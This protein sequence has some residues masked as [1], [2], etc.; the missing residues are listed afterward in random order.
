[1]AADDRARAALAELR[2]LAG[3]PDAQARSALGLLGGRPDR[4]VLDAALACLGRHPLPEARPALLD[5][6]AAYD[7]PLAKRDLGCHVRAAIMA[8][9][10]HVARGADL[11]VVER[12]LATYAF[13]P[14]GP[15]EVGQALRAAALLVLAEI[16]MGLAGYR[17]V[18]RLFDPHVSGMSGEPALTAVRVLA[19]GGQSVALYQYALAGAHPA[20][21]V[22]AECLKGLADAPAPVLASLVERHRAAAD[23]AVQ[24]GLVDLI[25]AHPGGAAFHPVVFDLMR[26]ARSHDLYHYLAFALVASRQR[27]LVD[28]LA[29]LAGPE[30][31]GRRLAS[32]AE[33]LALAVDAPAAREA[34]RAIERRLG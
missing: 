31:D 20:P 19:A 26:G 17:A 29:A 14:P 28:G 8:A 11:P 27:A 1:M 12:A 30:R 9:L 22:L 16:D 13:I 5:L 23:E 15:M 21:E 24:V 3:D 2:R 25:L 33:A 34:V 32:L 18:E 10:R 4:L 7:G 6:Y